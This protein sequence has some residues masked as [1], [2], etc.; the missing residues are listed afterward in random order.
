MRFR[1]QIHGICLLLGTF[2]SLYEI[3]RP[4]KFQIFR[5][6]R[7]FNSLYEIHNFTWN[8][9]K[10]KRWTFNSLYEILESSTRKNFKYPQSGFFQFSLWDSLIILL[11]NILIVHFQ[12][13]L[14][15]S[16]PVTTFYTILHL[17]PFNS[18]YEIQNNCRKFWLLVY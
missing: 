16:N 2:N 5:L 1:K 8:C 4:P 12:F 6:I 17:H 11:H 13:S 14:W 15:D 3:L 7:T 9:S 10:Y 18:L